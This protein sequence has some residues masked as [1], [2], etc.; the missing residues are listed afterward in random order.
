MSAS[1]VAA[2]DDL[3][4]AIRGSEE[5]WLTVRKLLQ[6]PEAMTWVFAGESLNAPQRPTDGGRT[7]VELFTEAVR[8]SL[9]RRFDA[10]IESAFSRARV[11]EIH[12]HFEWLV[13]RH[14]PTVVS[15]LLGWAD[16]THDEASVTRFTDQVNRLVDR[17]REIGAI[18]VL[19][20]PPPFMSSRK[21]ESDSLRNRIV[22]IRNVAE[23]ADVPLVDHA[24]RWKRL[25]IAGQEWKKWVDASTTLPN[26]DGHRLFA[27]V[28]FTACGLPQ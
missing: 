19:Q 6:Q 21:P 25:A 13:A 16:G 3:A 9:Q 18:P 8:C 27:E 12:E 1:P 22:A 2:D 10:V 11:H 17:V 26:G 20:T 23:T 5:A 24:R 15:V 4:C 28:L 14:Q 7:Y